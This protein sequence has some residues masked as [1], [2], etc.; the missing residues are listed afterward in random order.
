MV[1]CVL[2]T[3]HTCAWTTSALCTMHNEGIQGCT[4]L[5]NVVDCKMPIIIRIG[6]HGMAAQ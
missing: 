2:C 5:T 1:Y 6:T 3:V 4:V